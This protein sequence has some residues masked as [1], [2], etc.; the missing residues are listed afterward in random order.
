MNA[1]LFALGSLIVL[2]FSSITLGV[3]V[4][5]KEEKTFQLATDG[6]ITVFG[7]EGFIHVESWEKQQVKVVMHKN[8]RARTHNEAEERLRRI[9]IDI[10]H[11]ENRLYLREVESVEDRNQSFWDV[12][13]PDNWGRWNSD[14]WVDFELIVPREVNLRLETDEGKIDVKQIQG[15]LE[16]EVDEGDV[17]LTS[18]EFSDLIITSDEGDLYLNDMNGSKGM[19]NIESDEGRIRIDNCQ[20]EKFKVDSDEADVIVRKLI[21]GS[22]DI[23][24]DEGDIEIDF[25]NLDRG[26]YHIATDEGDV[27]LNIPQH[28]DFE[29]RLETEE[30]M[31]RTDFSIRIEEMDNG[32]RVRGV[33]GRDDSKIDVYTDEG[34]ISLMKK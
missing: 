31:I 18:I 6:N 32:A 25:V 30:G 23:N 24:T 34:R 15:D 7:G 19:L 21:A 8:A 13:D 1:K 12:L 2:F 29:L 16:I 3:E 10:E 27:D 17:R 22:I 4:N 26:T 14:T 20:V 5:S 9:S 28:S 11:S 33:I